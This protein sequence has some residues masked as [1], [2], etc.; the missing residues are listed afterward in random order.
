MNTHAPAESLPQFGWLAAGMLVPVGALIA[1]MAGFDILFNAITGGVQWIRV[2]LFLALATIGI[3]C[4]RRT[5]LRLAA[6]DLDH[7][8]AVA[9]GIG[10]FAALYVAAVDLVVFRHSLPANYVVFFSGHTLSERLVYFTLRAFNEE[11]FYRL[12]FMSTV[13]FGMGLVWRDSKGNISRSAYWIAI[14]LAQAIPV[15]LNEVP[16]YPSPLTAIFLIYFVVRFILVGVLWGFLY[17]RYGFVT[18][19]IAH[20]S[21][22]IFLQ[23]I[24]GYAWGSS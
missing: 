21:T 14:V 22:H 19:E 7:P 15:L 1:S 17:W 3:Y 20:V 11:I 12:F 18:A 23:P 10:L 5:G 8:V 13:L 24:M 9:F 16:F 2:V 6:N 4:A